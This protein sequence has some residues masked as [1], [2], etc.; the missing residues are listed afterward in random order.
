MNG[1]GAWEWKSHHWTISGVVDSDERISYIG[2]IATQGAHAVNN[3][4]SGLDPES[5]QKTTCEAG[6]NC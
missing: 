5:S 1:T 2:K 6:T 3:R 4:H